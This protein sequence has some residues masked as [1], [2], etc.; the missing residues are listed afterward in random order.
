MAVGVV[1]CCPFDNAGYHSIGHALVMRSVR[2]IIARPS[3]TVMPQPSLADGTLC[4]WCGKRTNDDEDGASFLFLAKRDGDFQAISGE[5]LP[6]APNLQGLQF[7][8]HA[9]CFRDSV[10]EQRR[11]WIDSMLEEQKSQA[12]A[13]DHP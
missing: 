2:S 3:M 6:A 4:I 5:Q 11:V 10:S 9:R 8:C 1:C 13:R 7:F 12:W